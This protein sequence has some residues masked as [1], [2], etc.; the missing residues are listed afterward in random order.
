[1]LELAYEFLKEIV[2]LR[3]LP[4]S[5]VSDRD[6]KFTS[7][8]W[9]ELHRLLGVQL[10]MTTAFHPEGNGQAEHMIQGVVHIIQASVQPDQQDWVLKVPMVEF[11][12]NASVNRATG[13][14]PFELVYGYMPHMTVE[15]PKQNCQ[16][17]CHLLR[18]CWTISRVPMMLLSRLELSNWPML[19]SISGLTLLSTK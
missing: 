17:W 13:Y 15:L 11:V 3:R 12:I 4:T 19:I 10:K 6:S 1:M 8:F 9:T 7:E 5:I 16:E 2:C 14:A 18:K